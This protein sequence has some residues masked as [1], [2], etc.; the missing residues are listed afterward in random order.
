MKDGLLLFV[1]GCFMHKISFFLLLSGFLFEVLSSD[2]TI[3]YGPETHQSRD[4]FLLNVIVGNI[5]QQKDYYPRAKAIQLLSRNLTEDDCRII[6]LFLHQKKT[7]HALK[8]IE[9]NSLKN[10]LV[11]VLMRQ[12][13][14]PENLVAELVT[15]YY[16]TENDEIWRDYCVQFMGRFYP[17]A[18]LQEKK[19]LSDTLQEALLNKTGGIAGTAM[20]ALN[21]NYD[22]I[23]INKNIL[24]ENAFRISNDQKYPNYIRVT[25]I[26]VSAE[27]G[28]IRVLEVIR[29]EIAYSKNIQLKMSAIAAL[30]K[31]GDPDDKNLLASYAL[32]SDIR[33]RTSAL[34]AIALLNKK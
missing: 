3:M 32:S 29:R 12:N 15:M 17:M 30:G 31:L 11:I 22:D 10:D 14:R 1:R 5:P 21:S 24:K 27:L 16:D 4:T 8:P 28:D 13:K 26:Q 9:F 18:T 34:N 19:L 7:K 20:I 25:A 33:L 2:K 6:Y 23:G